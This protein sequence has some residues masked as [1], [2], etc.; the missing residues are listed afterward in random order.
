MTRT[1]SFGNWGDRRPSG[2][3]CASV[4]G[5][6]LCDRSVALENAGARPSVSCR[7]GTP[8]AAG[9]RLGRSGV[10]RDSRPFGRFAAGRVRSGGAGLWTARLV[11]RGRGVQAEAATP[12]S[13]RSVVAPARLVRTGGGGTPESSSRSG[14]GRLLVAETSVQIVNIEGVGVEGAGPSELGDLVGGEG[15]GIAAEELDDALVARR[16]A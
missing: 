1:L 12:P 5:P 7:S 15:A 8:Q 6:H 4:H 13:A 16:A 10:S 14:G 2:I 9:G 11:G 3:R